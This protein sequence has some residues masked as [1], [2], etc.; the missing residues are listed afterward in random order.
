MRKFLFTLS[1]L[2][3]GIG[4]TQA[5]VAYQKARILDNVYLGVE[6]GATTPF[7]LKSIAP[8]NTW[9]GIKLGKNFSP[10]F[11]ANLEGLVN[12]GDHGMANSHT[13]ARVVNLG[14][15]GTINLTNLFSDYTPEKTFNLIT[16]AGLGYLMFYGDPTLVSVNNYGDDSELS[17]KVGVILAWDLG[18]SKAWQF[19]AEPAIIWNLTPGPGDDIRFDSHV[20]QLGV[21]AGLN[22]KFKTSNGTHGF[23]KYDIGAMNDE[24]NSL[25]DQLAAK[26]KEVVKEVVKVKEVTK[27]VPSVSTREVRVENLVFVTFAQGKSL[28]TNDA[29][30]VL[31]SIKP[32][33]HVQ[34]VGTASPEGPKELNDRLSQARADAVAGYL[35]ARGVA[36]DEATGKG[37]QGT[38]SNRLAVVYVK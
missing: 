7:Q 17:G 8:L 2:A 27:E 20:A 32:G 14:F 5:Q 15:N 9:A 31:S 37:V 12:F 23:K 1:M 16:E 30:K 36:V 38:T 24:I 21:F 28:L 3:L 18:K 33:S 22:Y 29:R 13:F 10:I 4:S 25:R 19:Y 26:P 6:A 35:Q 11:G 34:V